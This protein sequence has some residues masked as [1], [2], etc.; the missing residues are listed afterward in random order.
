MLNDY[1]FIEGHLGADGEELDVYIG[2]NE[3]APNVHVIH[4]LKAPKYVD[5]D[6][7]KIFL[8]WDSADGAKAAFVA[9]RNDGERAIK[10]FTILPLAEF[11]S[12]LKRRKGGGMIHARAIVVNKPGKSRR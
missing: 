7:D 11:K 3:E 5:H 1:G 8:G 4:Q 12:K 2:D 6:E 10:S 9:H